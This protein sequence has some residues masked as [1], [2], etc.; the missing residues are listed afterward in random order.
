MRRPRRVGRPQPT[1]GRKC[2]L[3]WLSRSGKHGHPDRAPTIRN[4]AQPRAVKWVYLDKCPAVRW[5]QVHAGTRRDFQ[6]D[7]CDVAAGDVHVRIHS[8][9]C[10]TAVV[11]QQGGGLC[12][13]HS[14]VKLC[15]SRGGRRYCCEVSL[16]AVCLGQ[17]CIYISCCRA[18]R[19]VFTVDVSPL[20]AVT[21]T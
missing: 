9:V 19:R 15:V 16:T 10:S 20:P 3:G 6:K 7:I 8:Y 12:A 11:R 14:S 17:Q 1:L 18:R 4:F 13:S 21:H 5:T 2:G